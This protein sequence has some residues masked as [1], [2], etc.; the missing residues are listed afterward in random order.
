[1]GHGI[2]FLV[3]LF[4]FNIRYFAEADREIILTQTAKLGIFRNTFIIKH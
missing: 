3:L 2:N 4:D 1:M